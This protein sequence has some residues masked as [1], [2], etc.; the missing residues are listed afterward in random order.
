MT[1][2]QNHLEHLMCCSN[3]KVSKRWSQKCGKHPSQA[4]IV[5]KALRKS[6]KGWN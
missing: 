2:V 5:W 4:V 1:E 6:S 3:K